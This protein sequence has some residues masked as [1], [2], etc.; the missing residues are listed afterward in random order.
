MNKPL[1]Q[2]SLLVSLDG[3]VV[4]MRTSQLSHLPPRLIK[5]RQEHR[6]FTP[7]RRQVFQKLWSLAVVTVCKQNKA[8]WV[9]TEIL[10][11]DVNWKGFL[12]LTV[13]EK[14]ELFLNTHLQPM[15]KTIAKCYYVV[16]FVYFFF[17]LL[18][19][20]ICILFVWAVKNLYEQKIKIFKP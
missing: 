12:V 5:H 19:V 11:L 14:W 15:G 18:L 7:Q 13:G 6:S 20:F 3:G 4:A 16:K 17:V 2:V 9:Q 8:W 10:T 1:W